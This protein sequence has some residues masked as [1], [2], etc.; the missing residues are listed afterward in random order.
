MHSRP[1]EPA[2]AASR[3]AEPAHGGSPQLCAVAAA[4]R[5]AVCPRLTA[6]SSEPSHCMHTHSSP[7]VHIW[8]GV[9][10]RALRP[11]CRR[12]LL[13]DDRVQHARRRA[14]VA[15]DGGRA[16]R[17]PRRAGQPT[18]GR[19]PLARAPRRVTAGVVGS[20]AKVAPVVR[21]GARAAACLPSRRVQD[22]LCARAAPARRP[23]QTITFRIQVTQPTPSTAPCRLPSGPP[24]RAQAPGGA[25]TLDSVAR[26][27]PCLLS[28]AQTTTL[29]RRGQLAE[30]PRQPTDVVP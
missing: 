19:S 21:R 18:R 16:G 10:S 14:P 5:R 25:H 22:E 8:P 6:W 12:I 29:S 4:P 20:G 1:A 3:P 30:R 28:G 26:L 13:L 23:S 7:Y 9:P 17:P 27:L 15:W 11:T 24:H 2:H